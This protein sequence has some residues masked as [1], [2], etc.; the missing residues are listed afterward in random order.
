MKFFELNVRIYYST[1]A[2]FGIRTR[3]KLLSYIAIDHRR[4][5][6]IIIR[7][8]FFFIFFFFFFGT[9]S[10]NRHIPD[11]RGRRPVN[12]RVRKSLARRRRIARVPN[13]NER[14]S[15]IALKADD[16]TTT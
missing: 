12:P 16:R 8:P 4:G 9:I 5:I 13:T 3:G 15:S 2:V 10:Q 7:R 1:R 6:I 14:K 11:H